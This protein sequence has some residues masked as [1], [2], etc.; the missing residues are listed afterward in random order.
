MW[1]CLFWSG[2]EKLYLNIVEFSSECNEIWPIWVLGSIVR[3]RCI[4]FLS[5]INLCM[6]ICDKNTLLQIG[7]DCSSALD[8][9]L[10]WCIKNEDIA[11]F[12]HSLHIIIFFFFFSVKQNYPD[13]THHVNEQE[14]EIMDMWRDHQVCTNHKYTLV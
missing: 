10:T 1:K 12:I 2:D 14:N 11:Q 9:K 7:I 8:N 13:E 6:H 5:N 3:Q 4:G